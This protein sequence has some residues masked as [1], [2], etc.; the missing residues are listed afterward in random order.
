MGQ[1][2]AREPVMTDLGNRSKRRKQR[3]CF[4]ADSKRGLKNGASLCAPSRPLEGAHSFA[5]N[6]LA[7]PGQS[8]GDREFQGRAILLAHSAF[9]LTLDVCF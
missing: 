6:S 5:P 8:S 4:Y 2:N 7:Q 1:T 9:K 3:S